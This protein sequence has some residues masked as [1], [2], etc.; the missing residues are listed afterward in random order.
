MTLAY[1]VGASGKGHDRGTYRAG[2][3]HGGRGAPSYFK[4]R[5]EPKKP[6]DLMDHNC[7]TL[8]LPHGGLYAWEFEKGD[9]E[10]RVRV[11]GQL[12][13][14]ATAQELNAALAGLALAYVP[15]GMA[16]P[17]SPSVALSGC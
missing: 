2:H 5:P 11:D 14:N 17:L 10:L 9:R 16:K 7:I 4:T 8:R 6:Q 12:T 3:A 15:E 13:Y 1:E